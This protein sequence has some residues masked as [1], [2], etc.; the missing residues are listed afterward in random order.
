MTWCD[1]W[2]IVVVWA[3]LS[4]LKTFKSL[5]SKSQYRNLRR[6]EKLSVN[7]FSLV[8]TFIWLKF[9]QV[10]QIL[11]LFAEELFTAKVVYKKCNFNKMQ[12]YNWRDA[13]GMIAS[14]T[15]K[16]LSLLKEHI[17]KII[18]FFTSSK[19]LPCYK[20]CYCLSIL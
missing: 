8:K 1:Q 11:T 5:K 19:L 18:P 16:S 7:L 9:F 3:F 15:R 6:N 2:E 4:V 10:L 13:L 17:N 14:P 12:C 20:K